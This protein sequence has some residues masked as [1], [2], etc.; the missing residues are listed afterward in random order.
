[1]SDP[2]ARRVRQQLARDLHD[3]MG[4]L[5]VVNVCLGRAAARMSEGRTGE[6]L[7]VL[8]DTATVVRDTIESFRRLILDLAPAPL[9]QLGLQKAIRVAMVQLRSRTG[10]RTRVTESHLPP[11]FP[12]PTETALYRV[13]QGAL[14]NVVRHS[15]AESAAVTL[16]ATPGPAV[17]LTVE[18]DG[19]GFPADELG[20]TGSFGLT[21]MRERA[22]ALGG[23]LRVDS[24]DAHGG[25]GARARRGTR[26]EVTLPLPGN[27][28]A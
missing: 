16:A 22:E 12:R 17:V 6:A 18:D 28:P 9:D 25:S 14:A 21:T 23:R 1:M 3:E 27:A 2:V 15:R 10:I 5:A 26:I 8:E 20:V 24:G 7:G 19:V 11:R 4:S 13:L